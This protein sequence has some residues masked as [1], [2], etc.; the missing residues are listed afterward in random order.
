MVEDTGLGIAPE[1]HEK[2]WELFY[3]LNPQAPAEGEGL[4]LTLARRIVE[5]HDGRIWVESEPGKGSRFF[6]E[7][8]ATGEAQ[9]R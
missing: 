4:G 9:I 1:H 2:I 8:A 6:V 3:R 7:L 5:R